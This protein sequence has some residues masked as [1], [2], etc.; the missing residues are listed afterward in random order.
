MINIYPCD[1]QLWACGEIPLEY[2][3]Q[4][5]MKI[6][7]EAQHFRDSYQYFRYAKWTQV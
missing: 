7:Q 4:T 3:Q 5:E 1:L 2:F 6:V